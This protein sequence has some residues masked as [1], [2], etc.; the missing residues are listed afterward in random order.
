MAEIRVLI[1]DDHPLI[2]L[3]LKTALPSYGITVI[4]ESVTQGTQV[5]EAYE[6]LRPDVLILDI[7]FGEGQPNGLE[8]GRKLLALH[9][10]APIVFHSQFDTVEVMREA[11]ALG[12]QSFII[13]DSAPH[14]MAEAVKAAHLGKPYFLREVSEKLALV[15]VRGDESPQSRLDPR[16]LEVFRHMARGLTNTEIAGIL[17]LS[18]KTIS[19]TSQSIKDKLRITRQADITL[20]A[21]KYRLIEV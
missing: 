1:A 16:E 3:G 7:R 10:D 11:Y 8:I 20:M 19:T 2:A 18:V 21:V 5:I 12:G 15:G 6:R 17:D 9:P 14:G 4:E 13:K